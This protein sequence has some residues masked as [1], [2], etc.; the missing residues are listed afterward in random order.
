MSG[1][2]EAIV[3]QLRPESAETSMWT[4]DGF[5]SVV[6]HWIACV[7][8]QASP[9]E[10]ENREITGAVLS[11]RKSDPEALHPETFPAPSVARTRTRHWFPSACA[12]VSHA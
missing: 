3:L 6:V 4:V 5:A 12:D 9:P 1:A 11:T 8:A 7:P 2:A 10:G